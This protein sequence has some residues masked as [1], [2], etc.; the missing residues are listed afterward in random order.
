MAIKDIS[1][2]TSDPYFKFD[3][4]PDRNKEGAK[5]TRTIKKTLNPI[6]NEVFAFNVL[7]EEL[8]DTRLR[9][10]GYDWDLLG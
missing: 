7:P 4:I 2:G 8:H 3:L 10:T 5:K 1:A 6:Y 9:L